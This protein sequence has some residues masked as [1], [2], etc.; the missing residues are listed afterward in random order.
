[1]K[2]NVN[3][4]KI[5]LNKTKKN[6]SSKKDLSK[7]SNRNNLLSKEK[8]SYKNNFIFNK[9]NFV[10]KNLIPNSNS[11]CYI[12]INNKLKQENKNKILKL[13]N[14]SFSKKLQLNIK[15]K[16]LSLD[17]KIRNNSFRFFTQRKKSHEKNNSFI[18]NKKESNLFYNNSSLNSQR[19]LRNKYNIKSNKMTF[20]KN[21]LN[22]SKKNTKII[23]EES[24]IYH[25][26][27]DKNHKLLLINKI[28]NNIIN[29]SSD[30]I[31]KNLKYYKRKNNTISNN[32]QIM[33]NTKDNIYLNSKEIKIRNI[34]YPKSPK[35]RLIIFNNNISPIKKA[36]KKNEEKINDNTIKNK[37]KKKLMII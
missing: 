2:K 36:N 23:Q 28:K 7:A 22:N 12:K 16:N 14:N 4:I 6:S 25:K 37:M 13:N 10:N 26:K 11:K 20:D 30:N 34:Y 15:N 8:N 17:K 21:K 5:S 19:L 32:S 18:R 1:M 9:N 24:P 3:I 31:R 33:K 35:N 29:I 27:I